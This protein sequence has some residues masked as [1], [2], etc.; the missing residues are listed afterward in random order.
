LAIFALNKVKDGRHDDAILAPFHEQ[1]LQ[2]FIKMAL[3]YCGLGRS[4]AVEV[5]AELN[6]LI[7][8]SLKKTK[9]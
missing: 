9:S 7:E 4:K 2:G 6:Q 5:S 1:R 3:A 8:A